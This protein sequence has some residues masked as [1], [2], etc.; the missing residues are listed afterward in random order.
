[1]PLSSIAKLIIRLYAIKLWVDSASIIAGFMNLPLPLSHSFGEPIRMFLPNIFAVLSGVVLWQLAPM[2]SKSLTKGDD[3]EIS[4]TGVTGEHLYT[5]TLLGL[6]VYFILSSL[7]SAFSWAHYLIVYN[8]DPGT[9]QIEQAPSY[10]DLM[11]HL[12]TVLAG[13]ALALT[14]RKWARRLAK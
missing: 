2:I 5:A 14:C 11:Y 13:L 7:A 1:M 3:P 12:L 6:G 8:R 10:Y 9:Y 4:L